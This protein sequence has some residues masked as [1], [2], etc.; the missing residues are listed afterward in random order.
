MNIREI[1]QLFKLEYESTRIY[2]EMLAHG[3]LSQEQV[4]SLLNLD[5][6]TIQKGIAELLKKGFLYKAKDTQET[7]MYQAFSVFQLEERIELKREAINTLKH[8]VLPQIQQP[9]R[10]NL[11]K[12][13][14]WDGIRTVYLEILE[15][16]IHGQEPILAFENI[17][18]K[19]TSPIGEIFLENYL[20]KRL[21]N[22]VVAK[23][24][25]PDTKASQEYKQKNENSLTEI[26]IIKDLSIQG[27]INIVGDLVMSYS[28]FPPQGTLRRDKTEAH[29]FKTVFHY[30]WNVS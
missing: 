27:T 24:I 20:K 9:E 22:K 23:V 26:K 2:I 1:S 5:D 3:N 17:P 7:V 4:K 14:G 8:I 21:E 12:Y 10:V 19:L 28:M 25:A 15:K 30:V 13:E 11:M 6:Q 16:A 18:D 29:D